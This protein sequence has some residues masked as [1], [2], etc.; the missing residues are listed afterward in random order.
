M[1]SNRQLV[2]VLLLSWVSGAY[3]A[4]LSMGIRGYPVQQEVFSL[5][6][7]P[8]E[9]IRLELAS[10][11][12]GKLQLKLDGQAY[13]VAGE[14]YWVLTAPETA[15]LY[16]LQLEH[17]ETH[18]R[19]LVNLF[20]GHSAPVGEEEL[21]GYRTGPP[22]PGHNKYPT[23]YPQ[24]QLYFEVTADNVDTRLSEHFTLRQFLCKQESG[25]PKYIVLKESLLVLLEGLVQAVQQAGY[26]VDTFGVISGYRTS[27]YN[28]RIGNVPNSRHV[29]GDAMDLFVDMDGDGNMDDL[30]GDG[31]NNR[32]DVDTL[33]QI[34]ERFKQQP[35][36]RL[37]AGGVGRYYKASHH[38]G[39]VH[40]DA[41]GF[42]ARW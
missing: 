31:Q 14:G 8:K 23:F 11:D 34:V 25:Y 19:S 18:A 13:G 27:Y 9:E 28:R 39:F 17:K 10:Y 29:Y 20:V 16:Q 38:G 41:R 30:N 2:A 33:Y 24:P 1:Y 36:N 32:A 15:D 26:P 40:M 3:A 21:N 5:F 35:K 42:R 22:P 4:P 6:A 7:G 37:L 12:T